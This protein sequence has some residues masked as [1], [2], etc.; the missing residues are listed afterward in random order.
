MRADAIYSYV[1]PVYSLKMIPVA[2]G[3]PEK[4]SIKSMWFE[5]IW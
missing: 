2:L 1:T 4:Y 3:E 5:V